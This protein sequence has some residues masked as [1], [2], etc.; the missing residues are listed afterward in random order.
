[1]TLTP[2]DADRIRAAMR[3]AI[4]RQTLPGLA[5]G[6]VAG[7]EVVFCAAAGYADIE[8]RTPFTIERRQRIA[9][10]TK[11]MVGLCA[12]AL[13]DEGKLAIESH[14]TELLPDVR[15]DGPAEAM[16]LLRHLLTHTSGIGEAPTLARLRDVANPDRGAVAAPP[17]DFAALYPDGVVVEV[18]PGEKWA[19]CNNG[20]ALLGEIIQR[21]EGKP[22][23][24]VMQR[25]VF[26]PLKM[27]SSDIDD[28]DDERIT[29]CY[30]RAP[31]ED[32]RFQLERAGISIKDEPLVDGTN[33][34]GA[35]TSE[36]NQSSPGGSPSSCASP[37]PPYMLKYASGA[38]L[39][40]R[41][42]HRRAGNVR[43]DGWAAGVSGAAPHQLGPLLRAHAA[44]SRRCGANAVAHDVWPRRRL[45]RWLELTHR[46]DPVGRHR[47]RAAHE[48]HAR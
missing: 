7:G 21:V 45:L 10:I 19:Y 2:A 12:M 14:V 16:T 27:T 25:R 23:S 3:D 11:T 6:V 1:M 48:R 47:D 13:V 29:S 4:A 42:R 31:G 24:E 37:T 38:A 17:G 26:A 43:R 15:F 35:F 40:A 33:I 18:P 44:R 39:L 8:S 22:L 20:Y 28:V 41:R 9:S 46:C 32:T 30:H 34:L 5:V 36:F